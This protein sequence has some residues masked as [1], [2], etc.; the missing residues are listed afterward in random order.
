MIEENLKKLGFSQ[1]EIKIYLTLIR[2]GKCK[3]GDLIKETSLQRSVVYNGLEKLYE[4][5]LVGKSFSNGV[6]VYL[7]NDPESLVNEAE[8]KI[9]LA[10]KVAE[11]LKEKQQVRDREVVVYE[12]EDIIKRVADKNLNA[13]AGSTIYFLGPSKFGVQTNLERYW[14]HYHKK[15]AEKGINCKILYEQGTDPK[16]VENRNT[17]PL[18]EARYLPINS[19]MP[20]SFIIGDDMVGMIVPTEHPPLAFLIK[21]IKTADGLKKYFEYLWEQGKNN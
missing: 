2:L 1:N 9:F 12:G 10:K 11:E 20:I 21:S 18:C 6:A 17:L 19:E 7:S 3:A 16:I 14:Q 8:Q 5:G 4:R 13:K 15:R